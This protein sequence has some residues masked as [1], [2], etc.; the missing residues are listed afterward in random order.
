MSEKNIEES[1]LECPSS[2]ELSAWCDGEQGGDYKK[3]VDKCPDCYN[4]IQFFISVDNAVKNASIPPD[5]LVSNIMIA[6][7]RDDGVKRMSLRLLANANFA[8]K[9]AAALVL[10]AGVLF[11]FQ[12]YNSSSSS[13]SSGSAN[14]AGDPLADSEESGQGRLL[15]IREQG[16][17]PNNSLPGSVHHVWVVNDLEKSSEILNEV[18]PNS[19]T[20]ILQ[21]RGDN[22]I[23]YCL[24]LKDDQLQRLVDALGKRGWA[25][26][27]EDQPPPVEPTKL[28]M[29]GREIMYSVDIVSSN[30]TVQGE[31][32]P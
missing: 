15:E 24:V 1:Y 28:T 31:S 19:C 8:K 18:I 12:F 2:V 20:R 6:C 21:E 14:N 13:Q 7:T 11:G 5:N 23:K 30:Q 17:Q 29:A 10:V 9:A 3:H 32:L 26:L 16:S 27:P 22:Y 4:Q 25:L